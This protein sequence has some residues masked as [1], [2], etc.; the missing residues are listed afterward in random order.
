MNSP[1]EL[2]HPNTLLQS[3]ILNSPVLGHFS[4]ILLLFA[5]KSKSI[6]KKKSKSRTVAQE[7]SGAYPSF[8]CRERKR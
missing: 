2:F 5:F 4:L 6:T 7:R 3:Y 8:R 1:T